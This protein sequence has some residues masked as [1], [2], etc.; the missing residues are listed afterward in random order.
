[1][2]NLLLMLAFSVFAA[3]CSDDSSTSTNTPVASTVKDKAGNEYKVMKIGSQTWMVENYNYDAKYTIPSYDYK[4]DSMTVAVPFEKNEANRAKYGLLYCY[5]AAKLEAIAP[6]GYRLPTK[7]DWN[8]LFANVGGAIKAA[9]FK[10][11]DLW[12][13]P[14]ASA[15]NEFGFN[16][17]PGGY[18]NEISRE[19][20]Q[21]GSMG[22][23]WCAPYLND[24]LANYV[25]F[26]YQSNEAKF[27]I[28]ERHQQ[29]SVRYI[30]K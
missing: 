20:I 29:M 15:N 4:W 26:S 6:D 22:K 7:G 25:T 3:S 23:Y 2:K 30:K 10:S 13:S 28:G 8:I 24:T 18:S 21:L 1:M 9:K 12:A 19:F 27:G 11:K 14:N 16:A 17:V 5:D